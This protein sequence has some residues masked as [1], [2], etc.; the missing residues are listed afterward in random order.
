MHV[1]MHV[2]MHRC[3]GV[4]AAEMSCA[5]NC[6]RTPRHHHHKPFRTGNKTSQ[7]N[8]TQHMHCLRVYACIDIY[9]YQE[10]IFYIHVCVCIYIV[11]MYIYIYTCIHTYVHI[12]T[13]THTHVCVHLYTHTQRHIDTS[14]A[15]HD[16]PLSSHAAVT[17]SHVSP[18]PSPNI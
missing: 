7:Q 2:C 6:A 16:T 8:S 11:C 3:E 13:H 12:H 18:P 14:H 15:A 1:C 9:M 10:I 5:L 17:L 4:L